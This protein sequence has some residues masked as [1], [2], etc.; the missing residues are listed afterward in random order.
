VTSL[1]DII[2]GSGLFGRPVLDN[3]YAALAKY[4]VIGAV[5]LFGSCIAVVVAP[6]N[7][8]AADISVGKAMT[9]AMASRIEVSSH[10]DTRSFADSM[11]LRVV[12]NV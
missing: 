7:D 11:Y 5:P 6:T 9:Y 8:V 12:P 1:P 10:F 3:E 2:H 4:A